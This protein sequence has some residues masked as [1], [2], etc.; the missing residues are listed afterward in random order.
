MRVGLGG[1]PRRRDARGRVGAR[2][3][4]GSGPGSTPSHSTNSPVVTAGGH[5]GAETGAVGLA[6]AST[7]AHL[8]ASSFAYL[9]RS[10]SSVLRNPCSLSVSANAQPRSATWLLNEI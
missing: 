10:T 5:T 9:S 3:Q 4:K 6:I 1:R 7:S 8:F 2:S